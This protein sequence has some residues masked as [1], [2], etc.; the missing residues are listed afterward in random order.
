MW[1][2]LDTP[3]SLHLH[4]CGI[5]PE[6]PD[7]ERWTTRRKALASRSQGRNI[8]RRAPVPL[9]S[10]SC[11]IDGGGERPHPL[12]RDLVAW[13]V[14]KLCVLTLQYF[15]NNRLHLSTLRRS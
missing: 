6:T 4:A 11:D 14:R 2:V 8:E 5:L 13:D 1:A 7:Q 15:G 9:C 12:S 10:S 3:H